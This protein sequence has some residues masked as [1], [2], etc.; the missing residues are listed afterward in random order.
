MNC[1]PF[2]DFV[3]GRSYPLVLC[4]V[5]S[6]NKPKMFSSMSN[7]VVSFDTE[8]F[9]HPV[10]LVIWNGCYNSGMWLSAIGDA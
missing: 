8:C 2:T 4:L 9:I 3:F 6:V 5:N 10:W 7:V 1:V